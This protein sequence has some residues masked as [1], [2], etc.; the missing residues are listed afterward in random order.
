M[1]EWMPIETAPTKQRVLV[2]GGDTPNGTAIAIC[3]PGR[4]TPWHES[5]D[6]LPMIRSWYSDA[7]GRS[8]WPHPTHWMPLPAPPMG[9]S[10]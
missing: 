10:Q 7:A 6:E 1:S 9:A 4:Y 8:I 2:C 5:H 3:D